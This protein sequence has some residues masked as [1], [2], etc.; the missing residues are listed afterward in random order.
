MDAK[1]TTDTAEHSRFKPK[2][3][4][5]KETILWGHSDII[6]TNMLLKI[7][8]P[9]VYLIW[10]WASDRHITCPGLQLFNVES[11]KLTNAVRPNVQGMYQYTKQVIYLALLSKQK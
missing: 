9:T 5:V 6:R 1:K 7:Q 11:P 8:R 2:T 10:P 4:P 3:P